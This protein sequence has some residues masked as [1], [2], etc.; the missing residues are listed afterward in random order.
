MPENDL[1]EFSQ[2]DQVMPFVFEFLK[3]TSA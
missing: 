1:Q 3:S 2:I